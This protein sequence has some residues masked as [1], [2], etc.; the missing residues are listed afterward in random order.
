[1]KFVTKFIVLFAIAGLASAILVYFLWDNYRVRRDDLYLQTE[2]QVQG[3]LNYLLDSQRLIAKIFVEQ[4]FNN[5]SITNYL[6]QA[7]INDA[8]AKNDLRQKLYYE[9]APT[10]KTLLDKKFD[11]LHFYLPNGESFLRLDEPN[12]F[13]EILTESRYTVRLVNNLQ[14]YIEGFEIDD[15][16]SGYR[17]VFPLFVDET[18]VGAVEFGVSFNNLRHELDERHPMT[19]NFLLTKEV[20]ER[21]VDLEGNK[22]YLVSDL[23]QNHLYVRDN[24]KVKRVFTVPARTVSLI[25]W[26]IKGE[27]DN[28]LKSGKSF[29]KT[30]EID[31]LHYLATFIP[32]NSVTERQTGYLVTY[33]LDNSIYILRQGLQVQYIVVISLLFV[34]MF[35]VKYVNDSHRELMD[36]NEELSNIAQ[37][38]GEGLIV[39]LLN[40]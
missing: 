40:V 33:S 34:I 28:Q 36:K 20:L 21:Q 4:F 14:N 6:S 12:N 35:F 23:S 2:K 18:Y 3:Q 25:D 7:Q 37:T 5:E 8:F 10:Y 31:N 19:Y 30:V 22:N 15:Y 29:I 27:I 32:V 16:F 9:L 39:I 1:M 11:Y 13:G 38:I 17:Y 24:E 26:Y